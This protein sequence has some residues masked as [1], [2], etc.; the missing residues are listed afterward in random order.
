MNNADAGSTRFNG[1]GE[2][3]VFTFDK[4]LAFVRLVNTGENLNQR[5]FT[6]AVF[7]HQTV[8]GAAF[9]IYGYIVESFNAGEYLRNALQAQNIIF[10]HV[11]T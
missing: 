7:A 10:S 8:N 4:D 9:N 2:V 3:H 6:G 5:G 1:V 11:R